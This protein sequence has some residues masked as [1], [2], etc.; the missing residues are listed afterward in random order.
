MQKF[1]VRGSARTIVTTHNTLRAASE[2]AQIRVNDKGD[3]VGVY[4]LI[5]EVTPQPKTVTRD[6]D[7]VLAELEKSGHSHMYGIMDALKGLGVKWIKVK[8]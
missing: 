6:I 8:K 7:E 5:K 4:E 2:E 3:N 1:V